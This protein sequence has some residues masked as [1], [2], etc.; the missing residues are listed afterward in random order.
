MAEQLNYQINVTGNAGESVGSL[1]KQLR[2][3]QAEVAVL[4]DKF[5]ATSKEAIEAAK[6]AADLKDRIGD[7]KALT[8]AFN[9]DAKFKALS[10]SL[11]GVAGGFAAVQGA[12][13]LFG[14]ESKELEKQL[15]KVQ[16]ALALSQGLQAIGE[17]ID[18]WKQL[19][20]VIQSTTLFT[21]LNS[22]A[23]TATAA[24]MRALGIAVDT[25]ATSFRVLKTAIAAT[26]IGL[27]VI[28]IGELISAISN[29]A[30][31]AE[32]AK[33]AQDKLNESITK[34]AEGALQAEI[35]QI[36]RSNDLLVAQAKLRGATEKEILDIE[37]SSRKLRIAARNRF[38]KDVADANQEEADKNLREIRKEQDAIKIAEINFQ[39]E[40]KK[41]KEEANKKAEEENKKNVE[42]RKQRE[43]EEDDS[44]RQREERQSAAQKVEIEAFRARLTQR[45]QD[46]LRA[47]DE[48]ENKKLTLIRAG[49]FD[50]ENIEEE[51]RIK[52]AEINAKY[53]KEELDKKKAIDEVNAKREKELAEINAITLEDKRALELQN[54]EDQYNKELLLAIQNGENVI[55]LEQLNAAKKLEI[56]AKY[57]DEKKKIDA[58]VLQAEVDLQNAK[59][60][61][62]SA[63]LNLLGSLVGENEKLANALFV[64]DKALAIAKI[65]V[66]TQREIAGYAA[67]PTW[68]LLPDG[69]LAIKSKASLA[70]KLRAGAS[71]ATI[72]ATTISKF[73]GGAASA[74]FGQGGAINT[75]GTPIV[76]TQQVQLT[77]LNQQS[78]NAIGNS[79]IRAYVVETDITGNQKR[80]QAIKQR[81]RFG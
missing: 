50:F 12:I 26:G 72:A 80:I 81:A 68:T 25:T 33:E 14:A 51:H 6:R 7:A 13:G 24:T 46:V 75:A 10:A 48:L 38:N 4:S 19:G 58:Q 62:A 42:I 3:A 55:A 27:A 63:G 16:S 5:G 59:F 32:R 22:A 17:S 29:Y 73:K 65:V 40:E 34:S 18:S 15:L 54:L 28:A 35:D 56:D 41:R 11:A 30:S 9:P 39:T 53:D 1:K 20:A 37:Q 66:D 49:N 45:Q 64:A 61:A 8:D 57:L 23:N 21:R 47:E 79:A 60:S 71:I 52:L 70:A 69:G 78:I 2:E 31:A 67:N 43:K 74:N 77:Q 36:N 44:R 76:P